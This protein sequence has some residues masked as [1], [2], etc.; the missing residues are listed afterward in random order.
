MDVSGAHPLPA[1]AVVA[2]G[3]DMRILRKIPTEP[4]NRMTKQEIVAATKLAASGGRD[5][6][7][8]LHIV[9]DGTSEVLEIGPL[10]ECSCW[11]HFR[12]WMYLL[13]P[14]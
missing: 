6:Q 7:M 10:V 3:H 12:H 8:K 9:R 1:G 11:S 4:R 5:G 14:K 13:T 2:E